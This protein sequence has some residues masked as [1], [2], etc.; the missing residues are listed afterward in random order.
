MP[1][2]QC[3]KKSDYDD[4]K[5]NFR[6]NGEEFLSADSLPAHKTRTSRKEGNILTFSMRKVSKTIRKC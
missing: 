4:K 2:I 3:S 1:V 6:F 5:N